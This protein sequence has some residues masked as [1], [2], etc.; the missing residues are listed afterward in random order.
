PVE[1][2]RSLTR[3]T[4]RYALLGVA[5]GL[6]ALGAGAS[7]ACSAAA[8]HA[9]APRAAV[10]VAPDGLDT[11]RGT[12]SAPVLT[13]NRAYQLAKP[14]QTVEIAAG[15][16]PGQMIGADRSKTS[17]RP[18]TFRPEKGAAVTI[19]LIDFGQGQL[20]VPGPQG[21]T[22]QDLGVT[23]LRAWAGSKNIVWKNIH[24]EHFDIFDAVNVRLSGGTFG[25]CQAP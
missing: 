23:Y 6:A 3:H 21:V 20:G 12:A 19:D 11:N 4:T 15:H 24:G 14:G 18:V 10:Y 8:R 1:E 5:L 13:L 25:P 16:Y 7:T 17:G 22:L 2:A 9:A